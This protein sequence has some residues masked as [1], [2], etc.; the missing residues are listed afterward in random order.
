[1]PDYKTLGSSSG[2]S[3]LSQPVECV[4]GNATSCNTG[5]VWDKIY[6][7]YDAGTLQVRWDQPTPTRVRLA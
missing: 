3:S 1:M 7:M 6:Q 5:A 2:T 4:A